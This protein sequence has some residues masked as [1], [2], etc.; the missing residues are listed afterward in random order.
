M[1]NT[2][3]G[4]FELVL[5]N[6]QV[7]SGFFI[8]V[9]LFGVFFAM[10]YIVGRNSAAPVRQAESP[11]APVAPAPQPE[12]RAKKEEPPAPTGEVTPPEPEAAKPEGTQPARQPTPQ[13]ETAMPPQP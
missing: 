12:T 11:A 13:A 2:E 10:G 5:G 1:K 9:I 4:E 3:T 8:I 7:L 6:K